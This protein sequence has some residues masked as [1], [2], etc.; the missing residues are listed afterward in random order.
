MAK[1]YQRGNFG[2]FWPLCCL[3]VFDLQILITSFLSSNLSFNFLQKQMFIWPFSGHGTATAG[4]DEYRPSYLDHFEKN[5]KD[6][7]AAKPTTQPQQNPPAVSPH[8][9]LPLR[10]HVLKM[11]K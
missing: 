11:A 4:K 8:L 6:K 5:E 10:F 3:S 1:R 7:P 2:I 9:F